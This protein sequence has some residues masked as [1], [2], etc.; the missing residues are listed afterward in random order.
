MAEEINFDVRDNMER[1]VKYVNRVIADP[2]ET[3][4]AD[5]FKE[6]TYI[7]TS[8][9][10][11]SMQQ[12]KFPG[13]TNEVAELEK[14]VASVNPTVLLLDQKDAINIFFKKTADLLEKMN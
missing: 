13:L 4:P 7:L 11:K 8:A 2:I 5:E 10:L 9:V 12:A 1:V 6:A 14:A 3:A